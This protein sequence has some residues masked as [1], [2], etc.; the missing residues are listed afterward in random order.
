MIILFGD[1]GREEENVFLEYGTYVQYY[2]V[3]L[4]ICM[5]PGTY[6]TSSNKKS[7][8]FSK[9]SSPCQILVLRDRKLPI[10][11]W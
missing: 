7:F 9:K 6:V 1:I 5:Y 3:L 10:R 4:S 2:L 11:F 8:L